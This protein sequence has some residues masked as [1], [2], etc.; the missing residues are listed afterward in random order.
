MYVKFANGKIWTVDE[1]HYVT[2]Q[3]CVDLS[4]VIDGDHEGFLDLI[5]EE[6]VGNAMLSDIT[7]E[8]IGSRGTTLLL[9]VQ[10]D[11]SEIMNDDADI[12][13]VDDADLEALAGQYG[14]DGVLLRHAID[15][16]HPEYEHESR[17]EMA[18]GRTLCYPSDPD[19]PPYLRVVQDGFELM[20]WSSD[21]LR[22]D[23]GEVLSAAFRIANGFP[24]E[25]QERE[26]G[27]EEEADGPVPSASPR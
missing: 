22:E 3:C 1:D 23:P 18:G 12:V 13:A 15:S 9:R 2:A 11:V 24:E 16:G 27:D 5:S 8:V 25:T 20:H 26:D 6:S 7:Y 19:E 10:G 14:W 21:E 4:E 17:V